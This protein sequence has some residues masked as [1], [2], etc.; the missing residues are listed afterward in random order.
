MANLAQKQGPSVSEVGVVAVPA[1][2]QHIEQADTGDLAEIRSTGRGGR[3]GKMLAALSLLAAL[4]GTQAACEGAM[5]GSADA[6]DDDGGAEANNAPAF[7][8]LNMIMADQN[9][10]KLYGEID[11]RVTGVFLTLK[12]ENGEV[13]ESTKQ[14]V[15]PGPFKI[16]WNFSQP[17]AGKT[18]DVLDVSGKGLSIELSERGDIP[19]MPKMPMQP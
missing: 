4:G 18:V 8:E 16:V 10:V 9:G 11:E 6:S 3:M 5:A 19:Q 14:L 2:D 12:D 1:E 15:G 13:L 7:G 17:G